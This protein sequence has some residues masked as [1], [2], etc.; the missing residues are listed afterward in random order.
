[1]GEN[2]LWYIL[3]NYSLSKAFYI[4]TEFNKNQTYGWFTNN[5]LKSI[6]AACFKLKIID[7]CNAT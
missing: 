5:I 3:V 6:Y 4:L 1:M 2:N 7:I